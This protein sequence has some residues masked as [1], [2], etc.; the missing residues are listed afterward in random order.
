MT[1]VVTENCG[2]GTFKISETKAKWEKQGIGT[3]AVLLVGYGTVR[4]EVLGDENR[5][6]TPEEPEKM[7]S[8]FR[9]SIRKMSSLPAY[10]LQMNDRGLLIEG[11]KADTDIFNPEKIRDNATYLDQ[12]KYSSGIEYVLINGKITIEDGQ[13]NKT[14]NGKVLLLTE[15]K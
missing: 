4:H 2:S 14:L 1:T 13:Y 8:I 7:K 11:Y 6:P 10:M 3:N 15:N 5:A 9:Q 12:H